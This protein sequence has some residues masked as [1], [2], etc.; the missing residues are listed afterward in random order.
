MGFGNRGIKLVTLAICT[1]L[2]TASLI[3]LDTVTLW[4]MN[5]HSPLFDTLMTYITIWAE[6]PVIVL[7]LVLSVKVLRKKAWLWAIAFGIEGLL[8]NLAKKSINWPRPSIKFPEFIRPIE[9]ITHA[10]WAAFP[11]GHTAAAFFAT[12][13]I[14]SLWQATWPNI[15]KVILIVMAFAVGYS[16]IYLAQHSIEDVLVGMLAGIWLFWAFHQLFNRKDWL[17]S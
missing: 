3:G 15:L 4:I 2:L 8:I 10:Q 14:L 9:G 6:W 13:V 1:L 11:S 17:T 5:H 16:R 7:T 12:A